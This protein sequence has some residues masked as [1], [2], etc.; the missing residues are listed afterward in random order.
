MGYSK[1]LPRP[2]D[3]PRIRPY[4]NDWMR[5]VEFDS[6]WEYTSTSIRKQP[7]PQVL[8]SGGSWAKTYYGLQDKLP[9]A[10]C[11]TTQR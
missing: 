7:F 5:P 1:E 4:K 6:V 11:R 3:W 9:P 2:T 8:Q 10:T